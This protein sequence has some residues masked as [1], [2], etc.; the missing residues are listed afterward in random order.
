MNLLGIDFGTKRIGIAFWNQELGDPKPLCILDCRSFRKS[1]EEIAH[2]AEDYE[3]THL[4]LGSPLHRDGSR[5]DLN[6]KVDRFQKYLAEASRLPIILQDEHLS[7]QVAQSRSQRKM[8]AP[9]D[10]LAAATIL[11]EYL[12]Q[13]QL[14]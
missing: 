5:S 14:I 9:I 8:G 1:A 13:H 3:A 4:I 10:D 6:E 11:M 7:S 12:R 2:L